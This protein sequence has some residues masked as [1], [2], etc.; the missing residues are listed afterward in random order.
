MRANPTDTLPRVAPTH[1]PVGS[2]VTVT[3]GRNVS[4]GRPD[5]GREGA[6]AVAPMPSERWEDFTVAVAGALFD[7]TRYVDLFGPFT[8]EGEWDGVREESRAII[9]L[10]RYPVAPDTL[11]ARLAELARHYGQD[12][13]AWSYGPNILAE[14]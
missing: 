1:V 9:V 11:T 2:Q 5:P 8:G 10:T 13:I 14:S 7:L 6:P 3:I 4:T 12:A